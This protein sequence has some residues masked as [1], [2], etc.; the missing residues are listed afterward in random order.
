MPDSET[1][2]D[3][4]ATQ[5]NREPILAVL[6]EVLEVGDRVLEIGSGSGQH[7]CYFAT[8]LPSLHWQ[9]SDV[10]DTTFASIRAWSKDLG[11]VA[12]PRVIDV[13]KPLSGWSVERAYDVIFCANVIHISPWETCSGLLAGAGELLEPGGR[14]IF[15]GPF[16]REGRHTAPSNESF[17]A[18]LRAR[19]P[20]WGVRDLDVVTSEAARHRLART[21]IVEMPSNNLSVIFRR[22]R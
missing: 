6:R 13:S 21:R 10:E 3:Y 15:Y 20:R 12:S 1:R 18:G 4:P 2:L 19:D 17:D 5:R 9:P 11:N 7:A 14:L 22:E 16:M 8:H